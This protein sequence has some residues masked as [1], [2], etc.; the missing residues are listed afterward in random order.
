MRGTSL[1]HHFLRPLGT[2]PNYFSECLLTRHSVTP[3]SNELG[4]C[5]LRA[6]NHGLHIFFK[7]LENITSVQLENAKSETHKTR[8]CL[9]PRSRQ[10]FFEF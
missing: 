7:K 1:P 2:V 3:L 5:P 6:L 9:V 8:D 4:V 10:M